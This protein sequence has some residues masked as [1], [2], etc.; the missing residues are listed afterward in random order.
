M[1]E[2]CSAKSYFPLVNNFTK[3][4]MKKGKNDDEKTSYGQ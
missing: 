1:E 4:L 3:T 2:V